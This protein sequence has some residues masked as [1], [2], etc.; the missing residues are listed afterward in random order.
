MD[1]DNQ[2]ME[3]LSNMTGAEFNQFMARLHE[4]EERRAEEVQRQAE[5]FEREDRLEE[6]ALERRMGRWHL[7]SQQKPPMGRRRG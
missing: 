1:E 7:R 5:R 3:M 6:A 2:L 4:E